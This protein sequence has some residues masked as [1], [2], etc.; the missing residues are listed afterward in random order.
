[1]VN[2]RSDPTKWLSV[3]TDPAFSKITYMLGKDENG[4]REGIFIKNFPYAEMGYDYFNNPLGVYIDTSLYF[5]NL[6]YTLIY[7]ADRS[8]PDFRVKRWHSCTLLLTSQQPFLLSDP[9]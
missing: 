8:S 2:L 9:Y 4:V 6:N 5:N 3:M 1:V 7:V